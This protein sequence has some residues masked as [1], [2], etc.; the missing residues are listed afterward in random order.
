MPA[1]RTVLASLALLPLAGCQASAPDHPESRGPL[2]AEGEAE[3]STRRIEEDADVEYLPAAN[4]VRFV[5]SWRHVED[6]PPDSATSPAREPN[7][8]TSPW[9][10]WS[11][12]RCVEA[13]V[14]AAITHVES[15]LGVE[16]I[17]GGV[18]SGVG[19]RDVA[20]VVTTE[21]LL[22]R[23]GHVIDEPAVDF[24]TLR[25]TTPRVVASTYVLGEQERSM[26]VPIYVRQRIAQLN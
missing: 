9:E 15:T 19:D 18:S 7:Y 12:H 10:E 25:E 5:W 3:V 1:R 26:D 13:A 2:R 20:A 17:G 23:E 11:H 4:E 24:E 21:T 22:D 16:S 6:G 14:E 8:E